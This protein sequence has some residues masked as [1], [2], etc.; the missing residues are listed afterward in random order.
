[1]NPWDI[2]RVDNA[3]REQGT[4]LG[5]ILFYL[6]DSGQQTEIFH[7]MEKSGSYFQ[8][9]AKTGLFPC[10]IFSDVSNRR[11]GYGSN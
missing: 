1:M 3:S 5:I 4:L 7:F 6:M 10:V 9:E 2:R 8:K 11:V